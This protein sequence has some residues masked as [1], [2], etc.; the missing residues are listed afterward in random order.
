M[1]SKTRLLNLYGSELEMHPSWLVVLPLLVASLGLGYFPEVLPEAHLG[2]IWE[3]ALVTSLLVLLSVVLHEWGHLARARSFGLRVRRATL[4]LFGG[5]AELESE[6][7]T[8][9]VAFHY[10]VAG[11]LV[12]LGLAAAL[13]LGWLLSRSVAWLAA[14]LLVLALFNLG[15]ALL[16]M[17]PAFPLDG[18]RLLHALLWRI[19]GQ[20]NLDPNN[21][22]FVGELTGA[23]LMG[24]GV[25]TLILEELLIAVWL[26]IIGWAIQSVNIGK[27]LPAR[28]ARPLRRIQQ[29][30]G[31]A[32]AA[33]ELPDEDP[34][35][36]AVTDALAETGAEQVLLV[37]NGRPVGLI[38][39]AE[40]QRRLAQKRDEGT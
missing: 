22:A 12:N 2:V 36:Q 6:P 35:P 24:A 34:D 14:P 40:L 21:L 13:G 5:V 28:L 38:S 31:T 3:L 25:I 33:D 18:G 17:A 19:R 32:V 23:S 30:N 37:E 16:N 4:Y 9:V 27:Y 39:R 26:G 15:V 29:A 8:P 20:A 7:A 1:K 10:A 11:P